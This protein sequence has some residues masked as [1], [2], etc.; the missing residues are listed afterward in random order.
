[1]GCVSAAA[2]AVGPRVVR[3]PLDILCSVTPDGFFG[4]MGA[5]DQRGAPPAASGAGLRAPAAPGPAR[6]SSGQRK[7]SGGLRE[8]PE[9]P[10]QPAF[11]AYVRRSMK[12]E[13]DADVS[14]EVQ[15]AVSRS[16]LEAL[17]ASPD[18]ILILRDSG[19]HHSGFSERRPGYQELLRL[20]RGGHVAAIAAFDQ[21]RLNR[22]AEND[23]ALLRECAT[24]G[25]RLLVED[26][27]G[28]V[29]TPTGKLTFGLKAIVA[30]HYRNEQSA[31]MRA[32]FERTYE[33]G[34]HRGA[35]PF[36]YATARDHLGR[37][38][39]PRQLLVSE[40]E[41]AVVRRVFEDLMR[42]PFSEIS[43]AL[44]AERLPR[45][46][47]GAWTTDAVKAIWDRRWVYLGF[48]V[49][50]HRHTDRRPGQHPPIITEDQFRA[51]LAGVEARKRGRGKPPRSSRRRYLLR[52]LVRC[53]VCGSKMRGDARVRGGREYRYY[54]CPIADGRGRYPGAGD[55]ALRCDGRRAQAEVAEATVLDEIKRLVLPPDVLD[56][57]REELARRLALPAPGTNAGQ[58][59]RLRARLEN[60]RKQ[61]EWGDI[62]DV[63]YRTKR[64]EVERQLILLPDHE[65]LVS[66][67]RHREILVSMAENVERA[68]PD[69]LRELLELLVER[70]DIRQRQVLDVAWTPAARPF[71]DAALTKPI[72]VAYAQVSGR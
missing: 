46:A 64:E 36:G 24:R 35:D 5:A 32:M 44:N 28:V 8:N 40:A 49:R 52:G 54:A 67:D 15:E 4:V 1:M 45:P 26:G 60:L 21:S 29:D 13:G 55:V 47:P 16:R 6:P 18:Q 51:A 71:V 59:S 23:L 72:G 41:A 50:G 2:P 12:A 66:F 3:E 33:L 27:A 43:D 61:H 70:V 38:I 34:G 25:V 9:D 31:R 19:G 65:K 69:Q 39:H 63:E 20:V 14:D 42:L 48:V 37:V 53:A 62:S 56:A 30:E 57:A 11:V 58:R 68:T 10:A 17:G 7:G 22:N